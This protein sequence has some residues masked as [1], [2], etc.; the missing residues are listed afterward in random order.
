MKTL[1][2][3]DSFGEDELK[4]YLIPDA[5]EWL[6]DCDGKYA[7]SD[8]GDGLEHKLWSVEGATREP[9]F[10]DPPLLIPP[11]AWM[12]HRIKHSEICD[13]KADQVIITGL[14]P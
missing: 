12:E 5:P 6:K 8:G 10:E 3:F 4:F 13:H 2:I 9:D 11:G 7:N 1:L 14:C